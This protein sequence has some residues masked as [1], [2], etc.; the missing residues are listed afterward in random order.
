[1]VVLKKMHHLKYLDLTGN[2]LVEETG[3]RLL[4]IKTLPWLE[5]LDMHKVGTPWA[6]LEFWHDVYP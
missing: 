6:P 4:V 3:Y 1:M 2:P 5:I